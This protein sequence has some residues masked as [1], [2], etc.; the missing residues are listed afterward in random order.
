LARRPEHEAA[1]DPED[2]TNATLTYRFE[3]PP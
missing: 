1:D 3:P 2:P